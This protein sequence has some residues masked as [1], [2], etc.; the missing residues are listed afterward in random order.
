[1]DSKEK[2]FVLILFGRK[3]FGKLAEEATMYVENL[4][5]LQE[6]YLQLFFPLLTQFYSY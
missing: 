6:K 1:M 2:F 4:L 3:L 5:D